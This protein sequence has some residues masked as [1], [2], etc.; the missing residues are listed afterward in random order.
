MNEILGK[1]KI[2]EHLLQ[3]LRDA[4]CKANE[5]RA[6]TLPVYCEDCGAYLAGSWT[7]HR[8]GCGFKALIEQA[9]GAPVQVPED[10]RLRLES[11]GLPR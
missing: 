10:V 1:L 2:P 9:G 6:M 3:M 5:R 8:P 4:V 7:Q 11:L